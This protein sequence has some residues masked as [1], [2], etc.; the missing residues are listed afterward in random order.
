L[1]EAIDIDVELN[2]EQGL[3]N[4]FQQLSQVYFGLKKYDLASTYLDSSLTLAKKL[5]SPSLLW[6]L[7]TDLS[8]SFEFSGN[9]EGA[10]KYYR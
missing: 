6:D 9:F 4:R 3:V 5:N 1:S 7:Y 2:N 8:S 10:L